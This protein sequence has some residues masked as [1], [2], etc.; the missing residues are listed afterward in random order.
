MSDNHPTDNMRLLL[1]VLAKNEEAQLKKTIH[2][3]QAVCSPENVAGM[4]ILLARMATG[5]CVRAAFA[6]QNN[7]FSIPVKTVQQECDDLP[8]CIKAVLNDSHNVSYILCL[9]SDYFLESVAIADLITY[10]DQDRGAIY[11][12]SRALP[13][14]R[15]SPHYH[16]VMV[17][18]YRLFCAFIRV[19]YQCEITDPAFT[20]M[21]VPIQ[22]FLSVRF[23]QNSLMCFPEWMYVLL[24]AKKN[25]VEIPAVNLP[26]TEM[27][28]SSSI[29]TR[30]RHAAIAI[31]TRV[32]PVKKFL[33]LNTEI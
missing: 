25:I 11:K 13:G 28:N 16:A 23:S 18:L 26:R 3:L 12:F 29:A 15:F 4:V 9:A 32:L 33:A 10:A 6:L 24:R 22:L 20:V 31:R 30:L 19:L 14:G 21:I 17:L 1:V 7:D 5:G 2:G 27:E 8:A